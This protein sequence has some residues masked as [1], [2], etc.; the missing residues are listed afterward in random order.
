MGGAISNDAKA[1]AAILAIVNNFTYKMKEAR[2]SE[3]AEN[4]F[5]ELVAAGLVRKMK[6]GRK[7]V[8][9]QRIVDCSEYEKWYRRKPRAFKEKHS[10]PLAEPINITVFP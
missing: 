9:Y 4:A 7:G 6:H 3:R 5:A 1:L 8:S 10:F 2:P